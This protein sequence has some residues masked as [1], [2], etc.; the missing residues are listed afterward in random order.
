[1][2][3][4]GQDDGVLFQSAQVSVFQSSTH[5]NEV[6]F[7]NR[8]ELLNGFVCEAIFLSSS[9]DDESRLIQLIRSTWKAAVVPSFTVTGRAVSVS[10]GYVNL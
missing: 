5:T 10:F 4:L 3:V 8:S 2:T 6:T 7:K 9:D 1:M